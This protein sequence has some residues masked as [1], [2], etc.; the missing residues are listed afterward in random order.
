MLKDYSKTKDDAI[1]AADEAFQASHD[2]ESAKHQVA[3]LTKIADAGRSNTTLLLQA[4]SRLERQRDE[5]AR[6]L[7]T[8]KSLN[9]ERQDALDDLQERH[10]EEQ[11]KLQKAEARVKSFA[12][13]NRMSFRSLRTQVIRF[14][15]I[16][17][18]WTD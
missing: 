2:L 17:S 10:S 15:P 4:K 6:N 11:D 9:R 7:Q 5:L 13:E 1:R 12:F 16:S 8:A 18:A 14:E 3:E